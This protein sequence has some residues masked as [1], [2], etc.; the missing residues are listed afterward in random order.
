MTQNYNIGHSQ[1]SYPSIP[2][3]TLYLL[4]HCAPYVHINC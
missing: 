2:S 1:I 4:R 3:L